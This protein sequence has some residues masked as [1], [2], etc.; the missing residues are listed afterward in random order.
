[1]ALVN[2][3]TS[4]AKY[5]I[6]T[7]DELIR[8][9]R[10]AMADECSANNLYSQL[11]AS[12]QDL[13]EQFDKKEAQDIIAKLTEIMHDEE[14]HTGVLLGIIT[15]LDKSAKENIINGIAGNK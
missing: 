14:N 13:T 11:I 10:A 5:T 9:L 15:K 12:L 6:Y 3:N 4:Q 2:T 8:H 1:M 7:I